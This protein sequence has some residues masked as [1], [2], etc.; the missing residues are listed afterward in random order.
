M[1]VL[2]EPL[3]LLS[4]VGVLAAIFVP[5][6]FVSRKNVSYRVLYDALFESAAEPQS[7]TQPDEETSAGEVR[8]VTIEF[9]NSSGLNIERSHYERPITVGFG[10]GAR[11]VGAEVVEEKPDSIEAA[12]RGLPEFDPE[13]VAID[14][15]LLN[16]GDLL[17]LEIAVSNAAYGGV[18]VDGRIVGIREIVDRSQS[19]LERN[20]LAVNVG[21]LFVVVALAGVA[22]VAFQILRQTSVDPFDPQIV[23]VAGGIVAGSFVS[24][25]LLLYAIGRRFRRASRIEQFVRSRY[26]EAEKSQ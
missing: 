9:R 14:P 25:I 12:L 18:E 2:L 5:L 19:N 21:V 11:I 15:V 10:E 16:D 3:F 17:L 1:S 8:V 22:D 23:S 20:L 4:V 26:F 6:L 24:A 13:R 7:E